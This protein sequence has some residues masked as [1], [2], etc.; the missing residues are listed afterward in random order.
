MDF[1]FATLFDRNVCTDA[2][3]VFKFIFFAVALI[4]FC[5]CS[6]VFLIPRYSAAFAVPDF[7]FSKAAETAVVDAFVFFFVFGDEL[8]LSAKVASR[9]VNSVSV[10]FAATA[11]VIPL[12]SPA[13]ALTPTLYAFE[14]SYSTLSSI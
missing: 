11:S 12:I 6:A 8:L 7:A 2:E 5:N 10:S 1:A 13:T 9:R 14:A 4:R 3:E